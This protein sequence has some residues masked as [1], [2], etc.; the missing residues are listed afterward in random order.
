[1]GNSFWTSFTSRSFVCWSQSEHSRYIVGDIYYVRGSEAAETNR[2]AI[3]YENNKVF[4]KTRLDI[5]ET[6][7]EGKPHLMLAQAYNQAANAYMDKGIIAVVIGGR[8]Q[9]LKE[10]KPWRS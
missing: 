2:L 4:P 3:A 10:F 7:N 1:M 9:S 5:G 8:M 6:L